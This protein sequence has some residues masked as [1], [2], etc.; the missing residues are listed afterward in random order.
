VKSKTINLKFI[1]SAAAS[2]L[3]LGQWESDGGNGRFVIALAIGFWVALCRFKF[4]PSR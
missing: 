1:L 4:G 3:H 2:F